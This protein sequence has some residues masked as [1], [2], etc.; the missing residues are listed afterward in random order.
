MSG[1]DECLQVARDAL[2]AGEILRFDIEGRSGYRTL[3]VETD[4]GWSVW[5]DEAESADYFEE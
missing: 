2:A 5:F 1:F 4:Q 3:A